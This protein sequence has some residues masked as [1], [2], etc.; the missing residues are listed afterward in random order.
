[1]LIIGQNDVLVYPCYK[2]DN[3]IAKKITQ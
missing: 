2:H 3:P 1:M